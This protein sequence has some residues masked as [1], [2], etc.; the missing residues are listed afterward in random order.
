MS[1]RGFDFDPIFIDECVWKPFKVMPEVKKVIFHNPATIVYWDDNTKT[2]V[3]CGEEDTFDKEKGLA[4][5]YMKR[6]LDNKGNYNNILKE[7]CEE[8]K[9]KKMPYWII[10]KPYG[11][12]A[13]YFVRCS[14]CGFEALYPL[15]K[16]PKC[17][18]K[19][20]CSKYGRDEG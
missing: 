18:S 11:L 14:K 2:V 10:D 9:P 5:C 20:D 1:L 17:E 3:K 12:S 16:C 13:N 7:W 4:L 15:S 8:E 19:M 6:M